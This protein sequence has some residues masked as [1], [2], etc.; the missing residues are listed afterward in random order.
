MSTPTAAEMVTNIKTALR[1]NPG[2]KKITVD[3]IG[4]DIDRAQALDELKYWKAEAAK[5]AGTKP[6]VSTMNLSSSF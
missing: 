1:K 3:G 2:V 6:V 4:V 5:E